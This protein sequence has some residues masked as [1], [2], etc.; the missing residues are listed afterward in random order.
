MQDDESTRAAERSGSAAAC[1][2]RRCAYDGYVADRTEDTTRRSTA[3]STVT[4]GGLIDTLSSV[5]VEMAAAPAGLDQPVGEVIIHDL[6]EP[7]TIQ[8]GDV[9][10]AVG[11]R[12]GEQAASTLVADA[13]AAGAAAVV[14]K[15]QGDVPPAL[16]ETAEEHDVALLKTQPEAA[17]GQLHALLRSA[18]ASTG[19]VLE[20]GQRQTPAGDLFALANAVAM[21]V[22]GPITI[23]DPQSRVLAYSNLG[24]EI[25]ESRRQ[26]I[27]GRQVPDE[28]LVRLR[29]DGVFDE[30]WSSHEVISYT[31]EDQQGR[32][33]IAVR[34]GD[35]ILGSIWAADGGKPFDPPAES[36]L[37]EA[38]SIAALHLVRHRTSE[39]LERRMRGELLRSLLYGRGPLDVL[40]A[41]LGMETDSPTVVVAFELQG[42]ED[43]DIALRRQRLQDLIATHCHAYRR[44]VAQVA[45]DHII[46]ALLPASSETTS[47]AIARLAE[48]VVARA[49]S[50]L[51]AEVVVAVGSVAQHLREIP[52]SRDEADRVLR[53]LTRYGMPASIAGTADVHARATLLEIEDA[54]AERPHLRSPKLDALA[55]HDAERDSDY[56][57]TLRAYFETYGD[58]TAAAERIH[59]HPNTFRYRLRRLQELSDIDLDDHAER[60]ALELQLRLL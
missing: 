35:E 48:Q 40:A 32:M 42:P 20:A 3:A 30:L 15:V 54:L 27:L 4:L 10:L 49:R 22:G 24:H 17:W 41:R 45:V 14:F 34:A 47:D 46:Y 26:T 37:L 59:V 2:H 31:P 1:A 5:I 56:V 28:W 8:A 39:D 9:V 19:E 57:E 38:A 51:D 55:D 60:L 11:V 33:A 13:G 21:M 29:E 12:P 16:L 58:V 18:I 52:R 36:A 53:V 25:D 50:G 6:S 44:Q 23:E 7:T 43:P